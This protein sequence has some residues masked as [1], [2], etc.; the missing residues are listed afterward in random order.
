MTFLL[1]TLLVCALKLDQVVGGELRG[2][3]FTRLE[4]GYAANDHTIS[5]LQ[6]SRHFLLVRAGYPQNHRPSL[7]TIGAIHD[8]N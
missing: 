1:S 2:D 4:G 6:P 7:N 3:L 8:E 5:W